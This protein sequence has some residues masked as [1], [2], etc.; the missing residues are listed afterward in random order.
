LGS[1]PVRKCD[2]PQ[3]IAHGL[4]KPVGD[5]DFCAHGASYSPVPVSESRVPA[6]IGN[7]ACGSSIGHRVLLSSTRWFSQTT[8]QVIC[9]PLEAAGSAA[10]EWPA[11]QI[12]E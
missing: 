3:F 10:P 1:I 2:Q 9:Q 7:P 6:S 12:L 8:M 11:A 4:S 5:E